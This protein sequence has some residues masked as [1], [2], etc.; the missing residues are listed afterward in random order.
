MNKANI[1]ALQAYM[2]LLLS[3]GLTLYVTITPLLLQTARRDAWISAVLALI[4]VLVWIPLLAYLIEKLERTSIQSWLKQHY[5]SALSRTISAAVWGFVLI[6]AYISLFDTIAWVRIS[7]LPATP[8][9]VS[10]F[11]LLALCGMAAAAGIRAIAVSAGLLL[12]LAILLEFYVSGA[13]FQL[14]NY[15]LLLPVLEHGWKPI[16]QGAA[17][18]CAGVFELIVVLFIQD[19]LSSTL[20]PRG[21]LMMSAIFVAATTVTLVESIAVFGPS[22]A[23]AMRFPV[24]EQWRVVKFGKHLSQ[25]DF[26]SIYLWLS[27]AFIRISLALF[28]LVDLLKI[29]KTK[30]R[31]W[32]L[33]AIAAGLFAL[34]QLPLSDMLFLSLVRRFY[35]PFSVYGIIAMTLLFVLLVYWKTRRRVIGREAG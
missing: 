18:A 34:F 32:T 13:N 28:L 22:E 11:L 26:L 33:L 6:V 8:H 12:P 20:K 29:K 4:P 7:Y 3:S 16:L 10:A 15:A 23:A 19:H 35:I 1:T 9:Q 27:A 30:H 5:G 21:L 14:K 25:S 31:R 2:M 17:Y 24:Y